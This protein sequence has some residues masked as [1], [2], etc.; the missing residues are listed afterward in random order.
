MKKGIAKRRIMIINWKWKEL[1]LALNDKKLSK[2]ENQK[3]LEDF[4]LGKTIFYDE[5]KII[6]SNDLWNLESDYLSRINEDDLIIITSIYNGEKTD[7]IIEQIVNEY[8][9]TEHTEIYLMLH[10]NENYTH[11]DVK[12][13]L[14]DIEPITKCFLFAY[15]RDFIYYNHK[16]DTGLVNEVGDFYTSRVKK[17]KIADKEKKIVRNDYFTKVWKYYE[18]EF[19]EKVQEL[20]TI[21]LDATTQAFGGYDKNS[22]AKIQLIEFLENS[23]DLIYIRL[24]SFL[25]YYDNIEQYSFEK[26]ET[27]ENELKRLSSYEKIKGKSFI[28]DDAK[29]NLRHVEQPK[30]EDVKKAYDHLST[31]MKPIYMVETPK[32]IITRDDID[33]IS[34][35]FDDLLQAI[36]IVRDE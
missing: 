7:K 11:D 34:K 35:G 15:G 6:R 31:L 14:D 5:Y 24:K 20:E 25:G 19:R 4:K 18:V 17:R 8:Y 36:E 29:E 27:Y 33:K 21:V 12:R 3:Y 9:K 16:H 2:K 10:R 13:L 32:T 1:S 30:E 28:F 26:V 22:M 23:D